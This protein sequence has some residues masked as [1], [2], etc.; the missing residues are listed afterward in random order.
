MQPIPLNPEQKRAIEH[1]N[2]PLLMAAGAGS[3][4]TRALTGRLKALIERGVAPHEIVAITFTNKAA[5]EMRERVFGRDRADQKWHPHF[6]VYGEPFIGTFHSFGAKLLKQEA[7]LL[8]RTAAFTIYDD[9]DSLSLV[10]KVCKAMD[11]DKETFKPS[12][13][14]SRIGTVKSELKEP[15]A[16]LDSSN[17]QDQIFFDIFNR[18]ERSL[19]EH[20]AFDFDDLIEKPVRLL[21]SNAGLRE[22]YQKLFSHILVDEY[23]DINTAQYQLIRILAAGHQNLSV[24]GDDFQSIYAF[25]GADFRNFLN[26]TRDWPQATVIKLEQNYRSSGNIITAASAV[27]SQNKRQTPKKLWTENPSGRPVQIIAA[28]DPGT[29]ADWV[30]EEIRRLRRLDPHVETAVIYRTNAQSR[31]I[32]QSLISLNIPYKIYG[33]LKFYDRKEVR[34][35]LAALRLAS[36]PRDAVSVERLQKSLGKRASAPVVEQLSGRGAERS[37]EEL[38]QQFLSLSDY[39]TLLQKD[40]NNPDERLENITELAI[41]AG[42][43]ATL[44]EFLERAALL[45]SADAPAGQQAERNFG[46]SERPNPVNLMTIHI[47]KGLEFDHVFIVGC[48]EGV[49][50]HERSMVSEDQIEEERRLMYVAMTRARKTL[51]IIYSAFASRFV[52]EIPRGLCNFTST[53]GLSDELPSEDDMWIEQ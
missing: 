37:A 32:E 47:A 33:G 46:Q 25:R 3:G 18:Y 50:P 51:Y 29:E 38:I 13:L 42:S 8:G 10:K 6:P 52:Y 17:R 12:A 40:F 11:L 22:R 39:K 53:N 41:F 34:D 30:A 35:V 19:A 27:I 31:A 20:N 2:G 36:N 28:D 1:G 43:F 5:R 26:F 7:A 48:N 16:F 14:L 21:M 15:S 45:S 23:Q 44:E 49:L 9:D 4:K 24:V